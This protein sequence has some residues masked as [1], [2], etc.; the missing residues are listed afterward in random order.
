MATV[1]AFGAVVIV[2]V[3]G[4]TVISWDDVGAHG[5]LEPPLLPSPP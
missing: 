4:L 2:G 5:L 3:S 1:V